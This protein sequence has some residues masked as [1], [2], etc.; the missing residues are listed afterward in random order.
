MAIDYHA[1]IV[2]IAA[3][4]LMATNLLG[5]AFTVHR[6]YV[7]RRLNYVP[8]EARST[9]SRGSSSFAA[10]YGT[11]RMVY[12]RENRPTRSAFYILGLSLAVYLLLAIYKLAHSFGAFTFD[13]HDSSKRVD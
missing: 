5:A 7:R 12:C 9:H 2:P 1:Y 6:A 10:V 11:Y 4:A 8:Q 13:G 3:L